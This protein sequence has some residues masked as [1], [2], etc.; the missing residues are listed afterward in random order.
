MEKCEACQSVI[1]NLAQSLREQG[2]AEGG[3]IDLLIT[4]IE[5]LGQGFDCGKDRL[6]CLPLIRLS[7]VKHGDRE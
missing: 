4:T 3:N 5:A 6:T 7:E 2:K 1:L